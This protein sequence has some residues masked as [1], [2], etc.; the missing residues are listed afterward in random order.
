MIFPHTN[1]DLSGDR[2][3]VSYRLTAIDEAEAW[4]KAEG[5]C[6][7]QTVEAPINLLAYDDIRADV[8]GR[9]ESLEPV[10]GER[11]ETNISYAVETSG[12]ELTQLLNVIFGNSSMQP[13]IRVQ[14]LHLPESLLRMFQGPHYGL[15][16]IRKVL[17]VETRPLLCT[18]LK[19]MGLSAGSLADLAYQIALGGIDIIKDDHGLADQPFAPFQERLQRCTDAVNEANQQSG[20]HCIYVP[21]ITGPAAEIFPRARMA[22]ESGAGGIMLAPGLTGFDVMRELAE[23]DFINLP[24]FSH[25]SWLGS[26]AVHPDNGVAHKVIFGQLPRLSGA[27][28][29]IFVNYGGRFSFSPQ[30][31][32]GI[33]EGASMPMGHLSPIFPTPGGGMTL[34]NLPQMMDFYGNDVILLVAGGLYE[35]GPDLGENCRQFR[36]YVEH[37]LGD[38]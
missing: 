32:L 22:S 9:I 33:V 4:K 12:F 28:A 36:Q 11:F 30:D 2:F 34:D 24:I 27:D 13:G 31:C 38:K 16:G 23:D 6:L 29:T 7:E 18:A 14:N 37:T 26:Y 20:Y 19:P 5:I 8:V 15:P 3:V 21:N 25:P 35:H 1:L 17:G 10:A